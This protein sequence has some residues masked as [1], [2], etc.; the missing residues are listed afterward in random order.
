MKNFLL[1]VFLLLATSMFAQQSCAV[2]CHNGT[3]VRTFSDNA[4]KGHLKH[5][6]VLISN[7]C[8]YVET[9]DECTVLSVP[10][11]SFSK[12]FPYDVDYSVTDL[13]GR[14]IQQ[15]VTS[16]NLLKDL[17]KTQIIFLQV[18]YYRPTKLYLE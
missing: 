4:L 12:P 15:G 2:V 1:I 14:I 8:D 7:D 6:D 9:G 5:G 11:F 10:K 13:Q 3:A 17:P 16:P 18:Q